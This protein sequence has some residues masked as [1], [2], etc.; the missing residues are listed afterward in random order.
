MQESVSMHKSPT[1]LRQLRMNQARSKEEEKE[2]KR[3]RGQEAD[4]KKGSPTKQ[5]TSEELKQGLPTW[6]Q[7]EV[8]KLVFFIIRFFW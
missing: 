1:P 8:N 3:D 2:R 6:A 5:N 4:G 7:V